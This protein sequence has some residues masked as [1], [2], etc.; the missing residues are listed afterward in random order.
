[1]KTYKVYYIFFKTIRSIDISAYTTAEAKEILT[2]Q[3]DVNP[4]H[5]FKV[6]DYKD[7]YKKEREKL[8]L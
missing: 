1:M 7:I 8:G 4:K 3:Y 5:I 2:K 6:V